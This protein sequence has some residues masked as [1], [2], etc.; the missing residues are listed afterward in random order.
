MKI[1]K[2]F[3]KRKLSE[4]RFIKNQNGNIMIFFALMIP[5]I[6]TCFSASIN[7]AY[8]LKSRALISESTNEASLA[9][10]AADLGMEDQAGIDYNNKIALYYINYYRKHQINDNKIDNESI[11]IEHNISEREYYVTYNSKV[12]AVIDDDPLVAK[13]DKNGQ[14]RR[15][16]VSNRQD[17]SGRTRKTEVEHSVDVAFIVDF[18]GSVTCNYTDNTCNEYSKG[19]ALDSQRLAYIKKVLADLIPKYSAKNTQNKFALIPYDI[20]VPVK[21]DYNNNT[22]GFPLYPPKN[23]VG[24]EN[25]ACSVLY[26]LKFDWQEIDFDFWANQ[27]IDFNFWER[28]KE[29]GKISNYSTFNYFNSNYENYTSYTLDLGKYDYYRKVIGPALKKSQN[30]SYNVKNAVDASFLL[31][32]N[33]CTGNFLPN[34]G[35]ILGKAPLQCGENYHNGKYYPLKSQNFLPE[36][37]RNYAKIVQLYDYMYSVNKNSPDKAKKYNT[38]Y[39][40]ANTY[41]VDVSNTL[42][43]LFNDMKDSYFSVGA[44]RFGN[45]ITFYRPLTSVPLAYS[46]FVGMCQSPLYNNKI[47]QGDEREIK[48]KAYEFRVA[49]KMASFKPMP[50]LIPLVNLNDTSRDKQDD[51]NDLKALIN[52]KN[53]WAPGGGTDTMTA[54]LRAVP[55]LAKGKSKRRV[56]III[57]D[58]VDDSGADTLRDQFLDEGVCEEI[59]KGLKSKENESNGYITKAANSVEIHY[60]K[61]GNA[62]VAP[63]GRDNLEKQF[64]KWYTKCVNQDQQYLHTV[65][66]YEDLLQVADKIITSETGSFIIKK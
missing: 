40:F 46:P 55:E 10:V 66:S 57:S 59:I 7:Y 12:N 42:T 14:D 19:S 50:R 6:F 24:G 26:T 28:L 64:G 35:V 63:S 5:A 18:S 49:E 53:A 23:Q 20:G 29:S 13:T 60:V 48:N 43:R 39:S 22:T 17:N 2:F 34:G 38:P 33:L 21:I 37:K 41:T 30:S 56:F 51:I 27:Y 45:I 1:S 47:I 32:N 8:I 52:D 15:M 16:S 9:I 25:Y 11:N 62:V 31:S 61:V 36:V 44:G 54:L 58:G 4:I 3:N 65:D